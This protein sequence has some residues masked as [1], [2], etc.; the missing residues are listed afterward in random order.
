MADCAFEAR[1]ALTPTGFGKGRPTMNVEDAMRRR[2]SDVENALKDEV[3][4]YQVRAELDAAGLR[5]VTRARD[6][7][8]DALRDAID[9]ASRKARPP[10]CGC[11]APHDA[12]PA[13]TA[14]YSKR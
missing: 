5:A 4:R 1:P 3:H 14:E 8:A 10:D 7:I 9:E 6:D 12:V 2:M 13:R 11:S